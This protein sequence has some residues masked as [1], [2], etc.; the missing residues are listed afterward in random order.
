[1][2]THNNTLHKQNNDYVFMVNSFSFKV[3]LF[4]SPVQKRQPLC[5]FLADAKHCGANIFHWS[6]IHCT[7]I[8]HPIEYNNAPKQ[9]IP[10][11][12]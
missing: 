7:M 9:A 10:W 3:W 6:S 12:P 5:T 11:L 4:V 8:H 2:R 1:M